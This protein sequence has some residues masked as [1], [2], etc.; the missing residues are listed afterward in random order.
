[1]GPDCRNTVGDTA[2]LG[3]AGKR[4]CCALQG[5]SASVAGHSREGYSAVRL[6]TEGKEKIDSLRSIHQTW[7]VGN[8]K[9]TLAFMVEKA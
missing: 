6:C 1:M 9:Q 3:T 8:T 7:R 2:Q 4:C 5:Y